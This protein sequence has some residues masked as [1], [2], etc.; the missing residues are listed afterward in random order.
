MNVNCKL[1]EMVANLI[2]NKNLKKKKNQKTRGRG[3]TFRRRS[4]SVLA[5]TERTFFF[6]LCYV[7]LRRR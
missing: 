6:V 5:E 3:F 1:I 2:Q 4:E 7:P